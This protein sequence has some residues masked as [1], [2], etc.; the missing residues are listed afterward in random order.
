M[1]SEVGDGEEEVRCLPVPVEVAC[2]G[3][4]PAPGQI[5]GGVSEWVE[6]G[7]GGRERGYAPLSS[8]VGC[9]NADDERQ[10][11]TTVLAARC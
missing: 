9:E 5:R 3:S 10:T 4:A 1:G 11:P 6:R 2:G 8:A 7:G